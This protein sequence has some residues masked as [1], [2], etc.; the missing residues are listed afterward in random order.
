ML[1]VLNERLGLITCGKAAD[2]QAPLSRLLG[3]RVSQAG[4]RCRLGAWQDPKIT[5]TPSPCLLTPP[6][7][8][9]DPF[10]ALCS[11][12][13]SEFTVLGGIFQPGNWNEEN[14]AQDHKTIWERCCKL[15]PSLQV[16][17]P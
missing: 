10:I 6:G 15:L 17:A 14:S 3:T 12:C 8:P 4:A 9:G 2:M 11:W 1:I 16:G 7:T 5:P 13:R